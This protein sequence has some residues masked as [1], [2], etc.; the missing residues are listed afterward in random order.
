M[1]WT[2]VLLV[3]LAINKLHTLLMDVLSLLVYWHRHTKGSLKRAS[4]RV[5]TT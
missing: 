4:V 2:T 5:R 3:A 1:M